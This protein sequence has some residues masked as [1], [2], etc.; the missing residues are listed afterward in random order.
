MNLQALEIEIE[1]VELGGYLRI[2]DHSC[3]IL[4]QVLR[5]TTNRMQTGITALCNAID[6]CFQRQCHIDVAADVPCLRCC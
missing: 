3:C 6:L 1:I 5:Y 4:C 2:H